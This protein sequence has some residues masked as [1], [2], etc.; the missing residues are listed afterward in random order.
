MSYFRND[1]TLARALDQQRQERAA[2]EAEERRQQQER[3]AD[4]A[5]ARA[6]RQ[7][8]L[9]AEEREQQQCAEAE[10]EA[11]L[12][13][14]KTRLQR[15]WLVDHPDRTATDFDRLA[16]PLLKVSLLEQRQ[17]T[18]IEQAKAELLTSGRY[19]F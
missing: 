7:A 12:A 1:P 8:R 19:A 13:A 5:R 14:D 10:L 16:W 4:N 9:D 2:R 15:Q 6:A 17:Q 11:S 3:E 18:T